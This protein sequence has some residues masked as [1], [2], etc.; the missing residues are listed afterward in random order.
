MPS[1]DSTTPTRTADQREA[2]ET[3]DGAAAKKTAE[4]IEFCPAPGGR[5]REE[6]TAPTFLNAPRALRS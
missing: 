6:A 2:H 4:S 3:A 1:A 5:A